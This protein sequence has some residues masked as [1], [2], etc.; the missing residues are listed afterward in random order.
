MNDQGRLALLAGAGL[1]VE[2]GLPT[3]ILLATRLRETLEKDSQRFTGDSDYEKTRL[4]ACHYLELYNF[5]NGGVRFQE[6]VLNRDPSKPV[7]IEQIAVGAIELQSRMNNPLAA[8]AAGWHHRI[9]EL[10]KLDGELLSS[11]VDFTYSRLEDWLALPPAQ[12]LQYLRGLGELCTDGNGLDIFTLNYDACIE[13][14]LNAGRIRFAN[15]FDDAGVWSPLRLTDDVSVRLYKLHGSLD[16]VDDQIYGLCSLQFPRHEQ[17]DTIETDFVRPLLIFGTAHKLSAREPFLTLAYHFSQRVLRTRILV[18]VGY[19]FGDEHVNQIV[20]QGLKKNADLRVVVV[21]PD[22]E[23]LVHRNRFLNRN[24]RVSNVSCGAKKA[25][26]DR[27]IADKVRELLRDISVGGPFANDG[28][29]KPKDSPHADG[30]K[31]VKKTHY[32]RARGR[33]SQ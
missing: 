10:E 29:I 16:W 33:R 32:S 7:N 3:S 17:A 5:I 19:S 27:L 22:A 13:N 26:N 23:E 30:K 8:Y 1:T 18:I 25:L 31:R 12:S 28:K 11:F 21:D 14:A 2:A 9:A 20:E 4:L 24:P 15:G 6:G